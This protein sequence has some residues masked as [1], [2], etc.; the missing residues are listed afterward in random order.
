MKKMMMLVTSLVLLAALF[1]GCT[2]SPA[3][4]AKQ[5][6]VDE[7]FDAIKEAY[8]DDFL[9]NFAMEE[10]YLS[11]VFALDMSLVDSFRLEIPAI[12][13]NQDIVLVVKAQEGKGADVE[14]VLNEAK[15]TSIK[16]G[17]WYPA[18]LPKVNA[19][20]VVRNGDYVCF[21]M[22]GA[23]DDTNETEEDRAA[24]AEEQVQKGVDAF[25]ALFK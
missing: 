1:A 3:A 14:A 7:I 2:Q 4:P 17:M 19:A 16:N 24:F 13:V 22:V 21:L 18:T 23:I 10:E 12:S 8:G 11:N 9:P 15:D 5:Y 20:K 25:N 6:S